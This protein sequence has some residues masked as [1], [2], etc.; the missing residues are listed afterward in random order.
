MGGESEPP[1]LIPVDK[2]VKD[3]F[4]RLRIGRPVLNQRGGRGRDRGWVGGEMFSPIPTLEKMGHAVQLRHVPARKH[5]W[6]EKRGK[7]ARPVGYRQW[8]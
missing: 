8:W 4:E 6:G 7:L 2:I 5:L 3:D 1:W